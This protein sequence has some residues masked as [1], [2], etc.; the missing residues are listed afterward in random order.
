L[1]LAQADC[2]SEHL[3]DVE[4]ALDRIDTLVSD[5]L[6]LAREGEAVG[7]QDRLNLGEFA[8]TCWETVETADASLD[9]EIEQ[10]VCA[11]RSR[12][13]QLFENC[14]RNAIEHGGEA[15]TITVGHL[16][17]GFYIEDDGPG[18]PEGDKEEVF[19][20]GYS[21]NTAGT[22]FGLSIIQQ[23]GEAHDWKIRATTG[24]AGGARF[25]ITGVEFSDE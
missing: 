22:G 19:K 4:T 2:D 23:V 12:L 5:L 11:D 9:I 13:R 6:T 17:G 3:D 18:I 16:D 21:T 7:E 1:R 14:Y 15:V 25:E 20:A 8:R 24:S 10:E